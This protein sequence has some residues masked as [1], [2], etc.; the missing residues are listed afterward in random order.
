MAAA[1]SEIRATGGE[2]S[3]EM[4]ASAAS[5]PRLFCS[6]QE[7]MGVSEHLYVSLGWL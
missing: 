3:R 6:A 4:K 2:W 7:A 1:N 5:G